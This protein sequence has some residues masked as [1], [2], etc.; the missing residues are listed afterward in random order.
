MSKKK[1]TLKQK[2]SKNEESSEIDEKSN[3]ESSLETSDKS[4]DA[5]SDKS[6]DKSNEE[7]SEIDEKSNDESSDESSDKSNDASSDESSDDSSDDSSDEKIYNI[8]DLCAGTGAFSHVFH[9]TGK[10]KTVF[11]NDLCENSKKIYDLNFDNK[12]ILENLCNIETI[13]IPKHDILCSGFPCQPFSIAGKQEGFNDVRS[14]IFWKILDI[15]KYHK[16]EVVFLE[17]VKNLKSHDDEKTFKII[18]ENLEK[19]GYFVK[20]KVINTC[21]V[22]YLP[23]NRER[24]YIICFKDEKKILLQ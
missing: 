20:Y 24:I 22:S 12:L 8:I 9:K 3:D 21:V 4:N 16:P 10:C 7:S 14:N 6:S 15:I 1:T 18:K 17:N 13:A 2:E 23:Q 5:S 11:A 19:L